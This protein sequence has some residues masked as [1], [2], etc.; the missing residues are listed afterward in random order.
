MYSHACAHTHAC[1][2]NLKEVD[3]A[4]LSARSPEAQGLIEV[5]DRDARKVG[6]PS[7]RL[8]DPEFLGGQAGRGRAG[9]RHLW[10][11]SGWDGGYKF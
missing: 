8:Q 2:T 5:Q 1:R 3:L 7:H 9:V 10:H 6:D 4:Q 11:R